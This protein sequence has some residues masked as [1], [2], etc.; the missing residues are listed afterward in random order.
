MTKVNKP[1]QE[2]QQTGSETI[3]PVQFTPRTPGDIRRKKRIRYTTLAGGALLAVC[4]GIAWFIFTAKSLS[5][6]TD[7]ETARVSL[8]DGLY[9]KLGD[10]Y[11]IRP[12]TY[13]L[14]IEAAGYYPLETVQRV[15]QQQNQHYSFSLR[16]LPGHLKVVTTPQVDAEVW[17]DNE[18]EGKAGQLISNLPY[19]KY[20][21]RVTA[22]RYL[23]YK[24]N[25]QIEGMDREQTLQVKLT[26]AWAEVT[27]ASTPS[28]ADVYVDDRLIGQTPLH[29]QIMQGAHNLRVKRTRYKA[30][31]DD[32]K[33]T[34]NKAMTIDDIVLE[35]ADALV[36]LETRPAGAGVTIDGQYSGLTP[37]EASLTPGREVGIRFFK[38]GYRNSTRRLTAHSGDEQ[39]L[40]VDLQPELTNISFNSTPSDA[41]LV[42]DGKSR[43][44]VGQTLSLSTRPHKIE[45]RC[46]GYVPYH[47]TITP[48]TGIEQNIQVTLKT[49][50]QAKMEAI[51]PLIKTATGQVLKLFHPG[52]FT[53]GASRREAGRRAN[54]TL[55]NIELTRPFYLALKETTNGEFRKFMSKHSSGDV[56]G[57]NLDSDQQ[58]VVKVSWQQAAQFCNWLSKQD[59]LPAFYLEQ[60]GKVI[61]FNRQSTGYRLPTEAEW[62]WAARVEA[63]QQTIRFPWGDAFPPTGKSGNYAD[64]SAAHLVG[65]ILPHY[66]DGYAATA[67]VGSFPPN[68]KGLY[69]MGGN[70]SEWINDF[71]D[72]VVSFSHRLEQDP[73]GPY[74]GDNHVIRGSSWAHGTITELRYSYRTYGK[75]GRDDLGFR[76]ARFLEN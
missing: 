4:L 63:N 14:K 67:P 43:G 36:M 39:H 25:I 70:V 11:L 16:R 52:R 49:L 9:L 42:I 8:T 41:E 23:P 68:S 7:P 50:Q 59:S 40:M 48:R 19:A 53:M 76:I 61:G 60:N 10:E 38:E 73:M 56:K 17:L 46:E 30:W 2:G 55:R 24:D 13:A 35:P 75:D 20:A 26:P 22:E 28:A 37:L 71:Y 54:E 57:E 47:A 62:A 15:T 66:L 65:R 27:V 1:V 31:Q 32:I 29:T 69:D 45:I 51:K 5:I 12:G 21:L 3:S 72:I 33:V 74:K 44:N 34:A 58:P 18:L 6:K 64:V